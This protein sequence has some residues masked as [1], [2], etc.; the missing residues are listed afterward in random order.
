MNRCEYCGEEIKKKN[1]RKK[2]F[3]DVKCYR[4]YAKKNRIGFYSNNE[5]FL[6]I[7]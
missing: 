6:K 3:C 5:G 4:A 1:T 7:L 2:R